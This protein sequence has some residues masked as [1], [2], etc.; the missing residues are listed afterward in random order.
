MFALD[1]RFR[2]A[3]T[4]A[5]NSGFRACGAR[6]TH[7]LFGQDRGFGW[8]EKERLAGSARSLSLFGG[9]EWID[10]RHHPTFEFVELLVVPRLDGW[11]SRD[12]GAALA[13]P[14]TKTGRLIRI[15][16]IKTSSLASSS[17]SSLR[18]GGSQVPSSRCGRAGTA[19]VVRSA[20]NVSREMK[21]CRIG[22]AEHG[23]LRFLCLFPLANTSRALHA[24]TDGRR[25]AN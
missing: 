17:P 25:R 6:T 7:T 10:A 23:F 16:V 11:R 20:D 3:N 14:R 24:Q 22:R 1:G 5:E 18:S 4:G 19:N 15:S 2:R 8:L 12:E 9:G 13:A 21:F